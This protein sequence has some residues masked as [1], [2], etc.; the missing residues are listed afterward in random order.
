[1]ENNR[2]NALVLRDKATAAGLEADRPNYLLLEDDIVGLRTEYK[3][4]VERM[5][6]LAQ[7]VLAADMDDATVQKAGARKQLWDLGERLAGAMQGIA[8][9]PANT[10][11]DLAGQ[12]NINRT[13]LKQADDATFATLL[14]RL[15][16]VAQPFA[17]PLARREFTAADRTR[18]EQLLARFEQKQVRQRSNVVAGSTERK[19]LLAL[20]RRNASLL[21]QLRTQLK[22]YK[23]SPTKHEVWQRFVSYSKVVPHNGGG[24]GPVKE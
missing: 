7:N 22:G 17:A 24:A 4:N 2:I 1:M 3:S 12:V 18:L 14:H 15:L 13:N 20:T 19:T 16:D 11:P 5:E 10:D 8:A 9:S 6:V 21:Q 23:N